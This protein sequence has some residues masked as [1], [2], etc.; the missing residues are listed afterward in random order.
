MFQKENFFI[1]K[2]Q[3]GFRLNLGDIFFIVFM[4]LVTFVS[5]ILGLPETISFLPLFVT[6]SFFLFCN[7]F[8]IGTTLEIVWVI[9]TLPYVLWMITCNTG[10]ITLYLPSCILIVLLTILSMFLGWYRGYNYEMVAYYFKKPIKNIKLNK[11]SPYRDLSW[12][13]FLLNNGTL[14]PF[15]M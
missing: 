14:P 11:N 3:P 5:Y 8:R 6:L 1:N 15:N 7:V 4:S 9:F 12:I 10:I 13:K 2:I